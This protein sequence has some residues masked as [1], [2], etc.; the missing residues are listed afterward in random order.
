VVESRACRCAS[1]RPEWAHHGE[2][3]GA[4]QTLPPV[5][6]KV[7]V[8]RCWLELSIEDTAQKLG[9]KPGTVKKQG[10]WRAR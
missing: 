6:R 1:P 10:G 7:I 9:I 3:I 5:P 4:L 2:I 8:L